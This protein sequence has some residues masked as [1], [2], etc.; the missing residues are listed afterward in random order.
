MCH[1]RTY[2]NKINRLHERCLRLIY[3]DK[4]SS[5]EELL[6]KDNSVSVHHKNLQALA[7]E[8]FKVY[9]KTSPEIMQEVFLL[10]EQGQYFL[11]NPTD[12]VVPAIKTVNHGSESI[13]FLGPKLLESLPNYLKNKD[14]VESFKMAMKWIPQ[15]CRCRLCKT[16]V[17]IVGYL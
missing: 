7:V 12:F 11:R 3:N 9:Y 14:S 15:S 10:N 13:R 2:N 8:M 5:F 17:Q 6:I 1:N 4:Q 16:Y